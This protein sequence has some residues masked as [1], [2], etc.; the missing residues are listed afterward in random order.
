MEDI[1]REPCLEGNEALLD[2]EETEDMTI[3]KQYNVRDSIEYCLMN[4]HNTCLKQ[5]EA[6]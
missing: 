5:Q 4:S 1:T 3:C 6:P 2:I